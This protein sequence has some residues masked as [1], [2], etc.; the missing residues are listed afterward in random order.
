M[1]SVPSGDEVVLQKVVIGEDFV[2]F[3]DVENTLQGKWTRFRGADFDNKVK[4]KTP[5]I[6]NFPKEGPK[7]LWEVDL[8]EGHAAPVIYKGKV[9]ILD[10]LEDEKKDALRCFDLESGKALWQRSYKVHVKRNHGMSRTVPAITENYLVTIG[11]LG[12]VMCVDPKNGDLLWTMDMVGKYH[13]AIPFWYTGQCPVIDNNIAVLAPGGKAVLIGVD[14][15]S[16]N[17]VWETPNADSLQMSHSSIM[18][19]QLGDKKIWVYAAVGAIVGIQAEGNGAG[20]VL[21]QTKAFS[22]SVVAPSPVILPN[23]NIFMTAGYGAGSILFSVD[24]HSYAIEV[25]QQFKPR[26]GLASEQQTP[27]VIGDRIYGI[28]PKDAGALRNQ[29]VCYATNDMK[30]AIWG[31]G[32]DHRFGLGPYIYADGK[33][34]IVGD[35]GTLYLTKAESKKLTV[36]DSYRVIEGHDA[37][38]PIAIADGYLLMR[39]AKKM[40]CLNIRTR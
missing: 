22:P 40:V 21:W 9:Y 26:E 7:I 36:L 28:L 24:P 39:D 19:M 1:D 15:A 25:L 20:K 38:G 31:S 8:G 12:H 3:A 10:Y 32:K 6:D 30:T 18:P 14:C 29:M 23:N 33:F 35:D 37:W 16:G 5:L 13:S 11:P 27:V 17:V 4:D 2:Q 34:F